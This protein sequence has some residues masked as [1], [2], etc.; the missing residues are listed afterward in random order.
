[1]G[2]RKHS[3][4]TVLKI[5]AVVF[6][7]AVILLFAFRD[8]LLDKV[9]ERI[10]ARM[11]RDY[12]CRFTVREAHFTG[13]SDLE[14]QQICLS[15]KSTDT[16]LKIEQLNTKVNFWK[17]FVGDIQLGKLEIDKGFIQL[18]KNKNGSNF[19]A[20]LRSKGEKETT[21]ETNYA[22]LLNRLSSQLFDLVPTN[23]H[24]TDFA[25]KID[26]MGNKTTFDFSRLALADKQL[27][28]VIGVASEGFS[29]QWKLSGFAD[30]RERKANLTFSTTQNDT[31]KL[32]YL[33]KKFHL[34]TGFQSIHF[35]LENFDM[36]SGELH[37]NGS[38]SVKNLMV[39]HPKIA[40]KDVVIQNAQLNYHWIV[41]KR[42]IALDSTSV[43]QLN[44]IKCS[45]Y[46]S[47]TNAAQKVYALRLEIPKMKAQDFIGSLPEGLFSHFKGMEAQGN[48]SYSLDFEYN[49][50]KPKQLIFK[51]KLRPDGLK[52]VKYGEADLR[53]I[54][55]PFIYRPIEKGVSG[56]PIQVGPS[57]PNFT[58]LAEISQYLQKCVLTSEDPS[59]F[60]HR[61][62]IGEAFRQSIEKNIRTK[63]FARG[64]ST[65]SMQLVKNVFL[66]REKTLSRKLEEILLVYLLENNRVSSKE[67][68]LEVYFNIIEWGPNVYGIGEAS[69]FYFGR[70]PSEL[71]LEQCL[72]LATIIPKPKGFMY[73]F[74]GQRNLKKFAKQQND[75]LTRL[76]VRRNLITENDT[77]SS[78]A[79]EITG[80]AQM[81]LKQKPMLMEPDSTASETEF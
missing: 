31:V 8:T 12:D 47:Y 23:M 10:D 25:L 58:P 34:K 27:L 73:R 38:A 13:L 46:I 64:A 18:V 43:A 48:F 26:D 40:K 30:P 24:V 21:D 16:L 6:V 28:T 75:F 50:H 37:I 69:Q 53:K 52:I 15:P 54:N 63:K 9:I 59:F 77:I 17:L 67:R 61:G 60:N 35:T 76:M 33:D 66:T 45:P 79:F 49:D 5:V 56:R 70:H 41:G 36:D 29:Q 42:S 14:F 11:V 22:Q 62:F 7:L 4:F 20:F 72:Y 1:M 32:P 55:E 71:S 19:D 74:D 3:V 80:P 39:N 2:I 51:S 81:Y 65:I 68:M 78:G 57:N 44:Q